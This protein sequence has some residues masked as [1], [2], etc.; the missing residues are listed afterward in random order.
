MGTLTIYGLGMMR[1]YNFET[2]IFMKF[3]LGIVLKS[4]RQI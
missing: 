4:Q 1:P 3:L 2:N